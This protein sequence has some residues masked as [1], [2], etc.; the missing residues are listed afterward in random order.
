MV[1]V[2]DRFGQCVEP[3]QGTWPEIAEGVFVHRRAL[4]IGRVRIATRASLWPNATLR[5]DVGEIT[6]GEASN[7]QDGVMVHSTYQ[8]SSAI[9]GARV[10]VGH[11]AVLHGCR[12]ADCCLI[13]MGAIILDN[14]EI[15]EGSLIGAGSLI[16]AN[17]VIPPGSMVFGSPAKVVRPVTEKERQWIELSWQ[18]YLKYA[19]SYRGTAE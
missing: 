10:T 8:L 6:I 13:G 16:T 1:Q 3:Y 14:A 2:Q 4:I 18:R 12:I 9:I 7:I 11:N 17:K 19:G 5:G 15:G